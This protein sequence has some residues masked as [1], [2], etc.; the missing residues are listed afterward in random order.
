MK[1]TIYIFAFLSFLV[2]TSL[3]AG[4]VEDFKLNDLDNKRTNFSDIK[5]EKLTILDFWATWCKPCSRAIPKLIEL[6]EDF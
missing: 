6:Y 2:V 4:T 1:R 3:T 5:G